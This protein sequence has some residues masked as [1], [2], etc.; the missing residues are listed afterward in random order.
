MVA[1]H[2]GRSG[3]VKR[4]ALPGPAPLPTP[5]PSVFFHRLP[6]L[7]ANAYLSGSFSCLLRARSASIS[8]KRTL[9]AKAQSLQAQFYQQLERMR[10][11]RLCRYSGTDRNWSRHATTLLTGASER[12]IVLAEPVKHRMTRCFRCAP[13]RLAEGNSP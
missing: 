11:F 13:R 12:H 10:R 6:E 4:S 1:S 8:T 7:R 9:Q 3:G 2:F 5:C